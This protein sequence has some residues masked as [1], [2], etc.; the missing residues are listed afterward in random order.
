MD[1]LSLL[2]SCEIYLKE[3]WSEHIGCVYRFGCR[4][5]VLTHFL[6]KINSITVGGIYHEGPS[7]GPTKTND[8]GE[9]IKP[10]AHDEG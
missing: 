1:G 2:G 3:I 5:H 7:A 6:K 10:R 8:P 9:E 4:G